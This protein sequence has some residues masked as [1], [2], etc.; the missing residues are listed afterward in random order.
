[1]AKPQAIGSGEGDAA[2]KE[3][4]IAAEII[5][6]RGK[7]MASF[8]PKASRHPKENAQPIL[9]APNPVLLQ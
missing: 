5:L 7:E 6:E 2:I 9:K 8:H 1:M 3:V 4:R